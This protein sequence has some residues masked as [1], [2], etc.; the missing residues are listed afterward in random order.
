[1]TSKDTTK[2][3]PTASGDFGQAQAESEAETQPAVG[4]LVE[5]DGRHG[6]LVGPGLVVWLGVA[7]R[8]ELDLR[9]A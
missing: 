3:T 7:Q 8:C 2:N 1:M 9:R 6:L 4:D 5:H